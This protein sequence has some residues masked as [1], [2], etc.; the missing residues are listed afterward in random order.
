MGAQALMA[1]MLPTPL[2]CGKYYQGYPEDYYIHLC[3]LPV[4][5]RF[6]HKFYHTTLLQPFPIALAI[7][8]SPQNR[9]H[10]LFVMGSSVAVVLCPSLESSL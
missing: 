3:I 1:P 10:W 4:F 8:N 7:F 5:S 6:Q 2:P 9:Q